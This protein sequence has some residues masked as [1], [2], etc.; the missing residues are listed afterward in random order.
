MVICG[1]YLLASLQILQVCLA[2]PLPIGYTV[3]APTP[4]PFY[5]IG[6]AVPRS[7]PESVPTSFSWKQWRA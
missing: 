1:L 5:T 4:Q 2:P 6:P 3:I 7:A